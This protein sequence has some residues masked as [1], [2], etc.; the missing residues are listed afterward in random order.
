MNTALR[1]HFQNFSYFSRNA[2]LFLCGTFFIGLGFGTFWV[3]FNLYLKE[4]G[5]GESVIGRVITVASAGTFLVSVPAALLIDRYPTRK[6]LTGAA[7]CACFAYLG[8]VFATSLNGLMAASILAGAAFAVHNI[9]AAPF[10]MRNSSNRERLDL[11]GAHAAVEIMAGVVGAAGGGAIP[12]LIEASGGTLIDGYRIALSL[13][14]GLVL[15]GLIPY[16]L[17]REPGREGPP[18]PLNRYFRA[19]EWPLMFRIALPKFIVGLGAGLIIPFLNLYFRNR[20]HLP[21]NRIGAI[22]AVAQFLTVMAYLFGPAVAR[23]FGMIRAAVATELLSTPFFLVMAFTS[24]LWMA[25]GAFWFR[26]A[27]M[28]MNQPISDNFA[29]EMVGRDQHAVMN[30]CNTLV[31]NSAWMISAGIGG[32]LIEKHG[33]QTPIMMI[34]VVL[35][36]ASSILYLTL[37]HDAERRVIEPRRRAELEVAQSTA[38]A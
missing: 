19:R 1:E 37:F 24:Q 26:G 27:L 16:L 30:S 14:A 17:I 8:Q 5:Y 36:F 18:T 6:I 29:M 22:F 11:F 28:N 12:P 21:S 23:R 2:R 15:L 31:W 33:F 20:F 34:T 13:A 7:C 35:Y 32:G 4:L 3:L 9:A 10:F 25:V 38:G